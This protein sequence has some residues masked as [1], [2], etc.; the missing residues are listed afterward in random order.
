M[1][2]ISQITDSTNINFIQP[3]IESISASTAMNNPLAVYWLEW[4]ISKNEIMLQ[5]E[6]ARKLI[7][8]SKN[9][10]NQALAAITGNNVAWVRS[11]KAQIYNTSARGRRAILY[12][13]KIL[14]SDERTHWL[15]MTIG[16][17]QFII[18][19]WV[20]TWVLETA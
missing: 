16:S 4:Y 11:M 12:A 7:N 13:T 9:I 3:H 10:E 6:N 19:K 8:A 1:I 14:P 18:D 15:K 2:Y 5:G 20:A 17:T